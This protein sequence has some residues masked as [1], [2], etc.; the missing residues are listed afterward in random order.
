MSAATASEFILPAD[1]GVD[2]LA[3]QL[4]D[5]LGAEAGAAHDD[6]R[7]I[8]DTFDWRLFRA[9]LACETSADHVVVRAWGDAAPLVTAP[10]GLRTPLRS[11]DLPEG[12]VFDRARAA[13]GVR[14]LVPL[15]SVHVHAV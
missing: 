3:E 15:A 11:T 5:R 14:A 7:T 2:E 12:I 1:A 6:Q 4:V 10:V 9:G 13:A 8:V